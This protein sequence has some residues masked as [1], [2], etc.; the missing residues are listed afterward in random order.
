[1]AAAASLDHCLSTLAASSLFAGIDEEDLVQAL[2][3]LRA[4]CHTFHKGELVQ[5]LGEPF[6]YV[7]IL[8]SGL[9]EGSFDSERYDQVNMNRFGPGDMYG[10][11][12]ACADTQASPIQLEALRETEVVLLDVGTLMDAARLGACPELEETLL[13]NLLET[14]ARQSTFLA[15]KVRILGQRSLRDRIIVFLRG[16]PADANGWRQLPFSETAM[17][18]FIG[19]NRS[20]VSRELGRMMDEG[21]LEADGR[22]M[23]LGG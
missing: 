21:L 16:L 4:R 5:R 10:A 17:A 20:A 22:R 11:A 14:T 9:V 1:M 23:R 12:F 7:G 3:L 13:R 8:V 2:G 18:Q 15:R 19:A 6:R